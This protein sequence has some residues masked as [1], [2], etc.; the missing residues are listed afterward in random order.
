M[1]VICRCGNTLT[2][3]DIR[4]VPTAT[5][6]APV[7]TIVVKPCASCGA[8]R[9]QQGYEARRLDEQREN[10]DPEYCDRCLQEVR[11]C[12]CEAGPGHWPTMEGAA[13]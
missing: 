12:G 6:E 4:L 8:M 5:P 7:L 10:R 13:P 11:Y 9:Y 1:Q 3:D 2:V